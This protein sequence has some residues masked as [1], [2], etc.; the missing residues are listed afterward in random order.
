MITDM[1]M[2]DLRI[3]LK[4]NI[5]ALK[6]IKYDEAS[7]FRFIWHTV[8]TQTIAKHSDKQDEGI[9]IKHPF[10]QRQSS[11]NRMT[12]FVCVETSTKVPLCF[13]SLL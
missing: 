8:A 4:P 11:A 6:T 3:R 2:D 12:P 10:Y 1:M 5:M 7:T 9:D 13:A